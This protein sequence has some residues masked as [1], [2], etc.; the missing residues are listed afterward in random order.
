MKCG[1][2][3]QQP[4]KTLPE[5]ISGFTSSLTICEERMESNVS[6]KSLISSRAVGNKLDRP[7]YYQYFMKI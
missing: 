1:G 7:F 5:I 2:T 6:F 3:P 4:N